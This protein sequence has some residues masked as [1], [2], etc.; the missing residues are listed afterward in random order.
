[1]G[2]TIKVFGGLIGRETLEMW[3]LIGCVEKTLL[4]KVQGRSNCAAT[5]QSSAENSAA[6]IALI[7]TRIWL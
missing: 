2:D 5:S 1:M 7:F 4:I 3:R 6:S